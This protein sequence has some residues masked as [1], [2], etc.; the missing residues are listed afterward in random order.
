MPL[1]KIDKANL[2]KPLSYDPKRKKFIYFDDIVSGKEKIIPVESLS[3]EELKTLVVKRQRAGP[4]YT[5]QAISGPPMS[6]DDV[7]RA[8]QQ[9]EPFGRVTI[10]AEKSYLQDLLSEIERNL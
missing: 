10:A 1:P 7:V 6:R 2:K 3:D 5:V 8:I 4:D 9:D